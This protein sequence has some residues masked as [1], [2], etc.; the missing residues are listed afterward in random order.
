MLEAFGG[1]HHPST[2]NKK[3]RKST[4]PPTMASPNSSPVIKCSF[5][6]IFYIALVVL[7]SGK[8]S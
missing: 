5:A 6:V 1:F 2:K 8:I 4:N 3:E 7:N